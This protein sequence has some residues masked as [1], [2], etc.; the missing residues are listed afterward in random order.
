M[1]TFRVGIGYDVHRLGEGRPL[2]LGGVRV[3]H[4]QGLLGHSD[5]DVLLHAVMDALLGA[6]SLGD[7]GTHFPST[8]PQYKDISSLLLLQRV[9]AMV[10]GKGWKV[11]N[12]D[13]TIVAERPRL[14]PYLGAM[15]QAL[16]GALGL[17]E[18]RVSIMAKSTNGLGAL[19]RGE[20]IAAYAVALLE[21]SQ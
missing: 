2:F 1:T 17:P 9:Q 11:G 21:G 7:M 4:P 14:A 5:G 18:E 3:P 16:A 20:G 19:G 12:V 10:E 8:D 13:A 6:A 15:R